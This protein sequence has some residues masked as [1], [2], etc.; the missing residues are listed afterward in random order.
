M[1]TVTVTIS[2]EDRQLV[3]LALALCALLRPG[4]DYAIGETAERFGGRDLV[5]EFKRLN[6]DHVHPS[7]GAR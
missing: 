1:N 6:A 3:L 7:S 5:N 4:F 2:E